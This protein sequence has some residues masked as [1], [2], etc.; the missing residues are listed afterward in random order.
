VKLLSLSVL[1]SACIVALGQRY[2]ATSFGDGGI[3][4][5]TIIVDGFSGRLWHCY[6]EGPK[7]NCFEVGKELPQ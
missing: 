7:G 5:E 1:V 6:S 2:S 3:S 4:A